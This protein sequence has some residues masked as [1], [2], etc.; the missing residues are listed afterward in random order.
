MGRKALGGWARLV[1]RLDRN[2]SQVDWD[3]EEADTARICLDSTGSGEQMTCPCCAGAGLTNLV[4]VT[5]DER[6]EV[7]ARLGRGHSAQGKLPGVYRVIRCSMCAGAGKVR[8]K[9]TSNV[10]LRASLKPDN[11]G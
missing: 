2:V 7:N 1:D 3:D 10:R 4:P 6:L 11:D 5:N 9:V 8:V